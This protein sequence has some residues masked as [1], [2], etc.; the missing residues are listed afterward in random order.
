MCE[1]E[2]LKCK[3]SHTPNEE[4]KVALDASERGEGIIKFDSMEDFF[5]SMEEHSA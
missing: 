1:N 3:Y 2:N 4:T 5:N